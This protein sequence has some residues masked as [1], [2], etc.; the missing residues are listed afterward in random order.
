MTDT[1]KTQN[2]S[3]IQN[4]IIQDIKSGR[5]DPSKISATVDY[6]QGN[7][8]GSPSDAIPKKHLEPIDNKPKTISKSS[9]EQHKIVRYNSLAAEYADANL[10]TLDQQRLLLD[11]FD[12]RLILPQYSA[13]KQIYFNPNGAVLVADTINAL[14]DPNINISKDIEGYTSTTDYFNNGFNQLV[15]QVPAI[16]QNKDIISRKTLFLNS[17]FELTNLF[18]TALGLQTDATIKYIK[19][20]SSQTEYVTRLDLITLVS[21]TKIL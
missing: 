8:Q 7:E 12:S 6:E 3:D 11:A 20:R 9:V 19:A 5:V 13:D 4:K 15:L 10:L 17:T 18:M 2:L 1:L 21:L 14:A 16:V